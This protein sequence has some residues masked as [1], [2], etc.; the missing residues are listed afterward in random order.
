MKGSIKLSLVMHFHQ[1][2]DTQLRGILEQTPQFLI[3]KRRHNQKNGISSGQNRLI[4]LG[5]MQGEIF[6]QRWE[7]NVLVDQS[8]VIQVTVEKTFIGQHGD[9][10]SASLVVAGRDCQRIE[11]FRDDTG[12]RRGA[13]YFGNKA[14]RS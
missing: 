1:R 6:P 2:I 14:E 10:M 8:Q 9:T 3:V 12:R 13:L 11:F 7:R 4:N 5:L